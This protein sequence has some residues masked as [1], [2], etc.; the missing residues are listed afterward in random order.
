LRDF[1][2]GKNL[3]E[4]KIMHQAQWLIDE[5]GK[6]ANTECDYSLDDDLLMAVGK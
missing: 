1:G 6:S 4:S 2:V 3:M 5:V